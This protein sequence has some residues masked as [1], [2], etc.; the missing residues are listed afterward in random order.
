VTRV[1][2]GVVLEQHVVTH[3]HRSKPARS[4]PTGQL[5]PPP[6]S[7]RLL[8][9]RSLATPHARPEDT[10]WAGY[11]RPVAGVCGDVVTAVADASGGTFNSTTSRSP[12]YFCF[13]VRSLLSLEARFRP[14]VLAAP[15]GNCH[16]H[17][18]DSD[19]P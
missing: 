13:G 6:A 12:G 17:R 9:F 2:A 10:R 14:R 4:P 11:H 1:R 15:S 8:R 7:C 19:R 18:T 5:R 16:D 3:S